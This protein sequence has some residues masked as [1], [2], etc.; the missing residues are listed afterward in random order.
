MPS[1]HRQQGWGK[2]FGSP[3]KSKESDNAEDIVGSFPNYEFSQKAANFYWE[4]ISLPD[5]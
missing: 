2:M 4:K 1:R 5:L 3:C